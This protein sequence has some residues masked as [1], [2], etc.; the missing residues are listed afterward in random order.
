MNR[1]TRSGATPQATSAVV[2][3]RWTHSLDEKITGSRWLAIVPAVSGPAG[4]GIRSR[5][6]RLDRTSP[7]TNTATDGEGDLDPG[8]VAS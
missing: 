3:R 7:S 4:V 5:L 2:D 8:S 1:P 6:R